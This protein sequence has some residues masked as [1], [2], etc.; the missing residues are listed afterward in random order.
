MESSQ[1]VSY[2]VAF[3]A[4]VLSFLSPCVLPLIPGYVALLSGRSL[5]EL[6]RGETPRAVMRDTVL[7]ALLFGAGFTLVF[8]AMGASASAIGQLLSL[9][10]SVFTKIAGILI[11]LF[12]IHT[13]GLVQLRWLNYTRTMDT[14][15]LTPGWVGAGLMGVAFAFGWTPCIGPILGSILAVAATQDTI[16]QGMSLL[17]VYSLGLGVPFV[18]T[19]VGMGTFIQWFA[20]YRRFM[21]WGEIAAGI[22]LI[23]L[24]A[25]VFTN[26]LTRLIQFVPATFFQFAT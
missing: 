8:T 10:M 9:Y 19:A 7:R 25:L 2:L 17:L 18:L 22:L 15:H 20:R 16:G 11:I 24:G 5:E 6:T 1:S 23:L 12:G 21:R 3:M 26:Q 14:R 4:G 13:T